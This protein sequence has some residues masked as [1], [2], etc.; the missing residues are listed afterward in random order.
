MPVTDLHIYILE[1]AECPK[2][3]ELLQ[4]DRPP[5]GEG[6]GQK[7]RDKIIWVFYQPQFL[8]TQTSQEALQL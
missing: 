1:R 4:K 8:P 5:P 6:N 2:N 3:P 7:N